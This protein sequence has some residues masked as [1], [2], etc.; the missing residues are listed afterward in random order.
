MKEGESVWALQ[1]A[2]SRAS[3]WRLP[4]DGKSFFITVSLHIN[5]QF[6][7]ERSIG[8]KLFLTFNAVML[9]EDV[10][11]VAGDFNG[12]VWR[13]PCGS[14]R[15]PVSIIEEA[16]ANTDLSMPLGS[17]PLWGPGAVPGEGA[18]VCGFLKPPNFHQK[19]KVRLHG[20]LSFLTRTWVFV[21]KIKAVTMKYGCISCTCQPSWRACTAR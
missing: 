6:A 19:L 21:K 4:R 20:A 15:K 3:F 9:E 5:N 7:K 8:K 17:P 2:I 12:A 18:D 16:F 1:G 13:C 14:D 10:D 11:L